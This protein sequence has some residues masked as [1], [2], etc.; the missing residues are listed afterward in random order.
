M[1]NLAERLAHTR[2]GLDIGCGDG[3][4]TKRM[5]SLQPEYST[6]LGLDL[7]EAMIAAA[8]RRSKGWTSHSGGA[9]DFVAADVRVWATKESS[10]FS[11]HDLATSFMALHWVKESDLPDTLRSIRL[12]L[13]SHSANGPSWF[14]ASHHSGPT[15]MGLLMDA[16]RATLHEPMWQ[17]HF[18]N[19]ESDFEPITMLPAKHWAELLDGA[20]FDVEQGVVNSRIV[21]TIFNDADT[22][23]ERLAAAWGPMLPT[24]SDTSLRNSFFRD[25]AS[26]AVSMPSSIATRCGS[27]VTME[28]LIVDIAVPAK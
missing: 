14:Y 27:T 21:E 1:P 4:H 28:N 16:V 22:A 15:T 25:V 17:T 19:G 8:K 2:T 23:F 20:G 9:V 13:Q 12:A 26:R 5:A 3:S 6:M 18:P 11:A 24:L 10:N 7:S